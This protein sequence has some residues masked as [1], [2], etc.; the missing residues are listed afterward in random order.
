[1]NKIMPFLVTLSLLI[2]LL[3]TL[4]T[5]RVESVNIHG[6]SCGQS[7]Y[8]LIPNSQV[9]TLTACNNSEY[10]WPARYVESSSE[11]FVLNHASGDAG[12]TVY[13]DS[14]FSRLRVGVDWVFWSVLSGVVVFGAAYLIKPKTPQNT[15]KTKK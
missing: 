10:G 6:T 2:G 1:M 7:I 8:A 15:K 4:G 3:I 5:T 13:S 14:S 11:V 12:A 9:R